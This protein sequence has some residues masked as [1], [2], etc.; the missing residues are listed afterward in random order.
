MSTESTAKATGRPQVDPIWLTRTSVKPIWLALTLALA[1]IG[2]FAFW[3]LLVGAG[4]AS[5]LITLSWISE[6]RAESDE[7]PRD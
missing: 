2:L 7:L 6:S 3:P 1:L 5:A 4:I